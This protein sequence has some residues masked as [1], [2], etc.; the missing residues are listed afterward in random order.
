MAKNKKV[1]NIDDK[2]TI[3]QFINETVKWWITEDKW[4]KKPATEGED[5]EL[6]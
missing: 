1:V 3:S 2:R 4:L 5:N 6:Q